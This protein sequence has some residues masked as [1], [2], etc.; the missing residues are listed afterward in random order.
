M[1]SLSV[2]SD[3]GSIGLLHP[4]TG[5]IQGSTLE[6]LDTALENMGLGEKDFFLSFFRN[7]YIHIDLVS[8]YV[9]SA[10]AVLGVIVYSVAIGGTRGRN[11]TLLLPTLCYTPLYLL[12]NL[13]SVLTSSFLLGFHNPLQP[14]SNTNLIVKSF[15]TIIIGLGLFTARR[16]MLRKEENNKELII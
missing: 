12:H 4:H 10:M 11:A 9:K 1:F 5:Y 14:H 2:V 3:P 8:I 6:Q 7:V 13:C 16:Y 15:N